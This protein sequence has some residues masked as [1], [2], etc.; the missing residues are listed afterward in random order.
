MKLNYSDDLNI[1]MSYLFSM[2]FPKLKTMMPIQA[3]SHGFLRLKKSQL[4]GC[5]MMKLNKKKML[6]FSNGILYF[7]FIH[8][9]YKFYWKT[10]LKRR[11]Q[12]MKHTGNLFRIIFKMQSRYFVQLMEGMQYLHSQ[13]VVRKL[14]L[15]F[16][17]K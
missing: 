4:Y 2:F 1:V 14:F 11:F 8:V 16:I 17:M 3:Y 13:S 12:K 5:M 7:N 6:K 15:F 10:L 9:R